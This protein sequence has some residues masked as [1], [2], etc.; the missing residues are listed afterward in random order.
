MDKIHTPV[1]LQESIDSLDIKEDGFYIDGTLGDGGHSFEILKKLSKNGLLISIDQD[2]YAIDFV[3]DYYKDYL[4][5][6]WIIVKSN[7]SKI[8][9]V[10]KE[11]ADGRKPNG[12]LLDIGLSSRQ[13]ESSHD[14]GFSYLESQ[15]PLDMRMDTSLGVSAKD[16]LNV[17][18]EK[19][20]ATIFLKYGEE[21]Y[22]KR[23]A[24]MIKENISNINTVGDLTRLIYKAVPAADSST[25]K[26]PSRRVFQALRIVVNDELNSLQTALDKSFEVLEK[27]GRL[28]VIT[29]HSLEDRILKQF[30]K[31]KSGSGEGRLLFQKYIAPTDEE[32]KINPRSTSAKLRTLI[33]N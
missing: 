20:L 4:S 27:N 21:R 15:E 7:F 12:I 26:N 17:F 31:E 10:V 11:F 29:F 1:L 5:E 23:I 2:Q 18:S 33:K 28:S 22:A 9:Q 24:K 16:I 25:N 14:R 32:K 6:N 30:N 19:E 3:K 8:D 13:L